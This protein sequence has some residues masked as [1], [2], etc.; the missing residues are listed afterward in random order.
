[1]KGRIMEGM[2]V[3]ALSPVDETGRYDGGMLKSYVDWLIASGSEAI[4]AIGSTGG[5]TVF[6]AEERKQLAEGFIKAASGRVPVVIHIGSDTENE[7]LD[8]AAHAAAAGADGFAAVPPYYYRYSPECISAYFERLAAVNPELPFYIY[9]IPSFTNSDIT[10]T[11]LKELTARIPNLAGIKDTT[12]SFPRF[13][14]YCDVMGV[15]FGNYMGS[16]AMVIASIQAGGKGGICAMASHNPELMASLFQAYRK[17]DLEKARK[18]QF[19]SARMRLLL[20]NMPFMSTRIEIVRMRGIIQCGFRRP[21]LPLAESQRT[22]LK[23]TLKKL[24]DE[25]S[26]PLL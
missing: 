19:L 22:F 17:G 12:Q 18:L 10:P 14:D 15:D 23:D 1:M 9:N 7:A 5:F 20:Q 6:S 2:I 25:F 16:D 11:Q 3:A 13:V 8:L 21:F 26:F 24:E 4:F